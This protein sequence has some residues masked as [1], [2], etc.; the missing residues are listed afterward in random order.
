MNSS[1]DSLWVYVGF[2]TKKGSIKETSVVP[3]ETVVGRDP[4]V[5]AECQVLYGTKPY[6]AKVLK[7][8][9]KCLIVQS[10]LALKLPRGLST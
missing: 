10:V 3:V 4:K 1:K 8:S 6:P 9:S 2:L 5:D 7:I